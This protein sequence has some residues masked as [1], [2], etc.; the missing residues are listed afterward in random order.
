MFFP[1]SSFQ[2]RFT[3]WCLLGACFLSFSFNH[4]VLTKYH[5][6]LGQASFYLI[7]PAL[8][9]SHFRP[10]GTAIIW[11]S[12][13]LGYCLGSAA[14]MCI[15][16]YGL[17]TPRPYTAAVSVIFVFLIVQMTAALVE[18]NPGLDQRLEKMFVCAAWALVLLA[19][20]DVYQIYCNSPLVVEPYGLKMLDFLSL[21]EVSFSPFRL[22]GFTQE[23]SYL[24]M[25]I[26]TIYPIC[27]IRLNRKFSLINSFLILALWVCLIFSMSRT[28]ILVCMVLTV[29]VLL[30]WPKRL[31]LVSLFTFCL[32][33]LW[34]YFPQFREGRYG[35]FLTLSWVP[36]VSIDGSTLV[37]SAHIYAAIKA[38]LANPILGVG[39]GQSGFILPNYYPAWYGP[40]SPEFV[41]WSKAANV[42][43]TPSL[44]FLPGLLAQ[45]GFLGACL[46]LCPL[47]SRSTQLFHAIKTI[48]TAYSFFMAF[49]GFLLTS[50]GVD[51]YLYLPA[52]VV[53]GALVGL[54]RK[55][56][57]KESSEDANNYNNLI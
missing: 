17:C 7:V 48:P 22:R 49:M 15:S 33:V 1:A 13:F 24:G 41:G 29:L 45:I 12:A 47:I 32:V 20:P 36:I 21:K 3:Q 25:V 18:K 14:L 6:V 56:Q 35:V 40:G 53:L 39:L 38:W 19:L 27:L 16:G 51:G 50:F 46:C 52:W 44:S 4:I 30:S 2:Q 37:R 34:Q 57:R 8:L 23:P 9:L 43:G 26:A 11:V 55:S 5:F 31:L 28:G 42:G 54:S 10:S